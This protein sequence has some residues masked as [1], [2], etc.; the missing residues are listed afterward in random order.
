MIKGLKH[1]QHLVKGSKHKLILLTDHENLGHYQHLQNINRRVA[2]YLH[3][4]A[5]FD[6]ELQ[7]ISG[8]TNKADALSQQ[9]DHDDGSGYNEK[10]VALLDS[11]FARVMKVTH[12]DK[13][14]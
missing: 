1:N 2:R 11:L 12:F 6:P 13:E 7:H 5:E 9:P 3:K 4:L 8:K 14:I 10:I